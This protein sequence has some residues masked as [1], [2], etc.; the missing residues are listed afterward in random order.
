MSQLSR[1]LL[2]GGSVR[3][4]QPS[5]GQQVTPANG[6]IYA[7]GDVN[8][9]TSASGNTIYAILKNDI[10]INSATVG[11]VTFNANTIGS[12]IGSYLRIAPV[13]NG[14]IIVSYATPRSI[15]LTDS[16]Y[17]MVS[18]STL[19]DG[20]IAI[21][22]SGN[23]PIAANI[24]AGS[25]ISIINGP[26]SITISADSSTNGNAGVLNWS[27]QT[28]TGSGN[29]DYTAMPN[30]GYFANST[31]GTFRSTSYDYCPISPIRYSVAPSIN[32]KVGDAL[33]MCNRNKGNYLFQ[34]QPDQGITLSNLVGA[35]YNMNPYYGVGAL[36]GGRDTSIRS[37]TGAPP[38]R[39]Y[40]RMY[41]AQLWIFIGSINYNVKPAPYQ[42]DNVVYRQYD[43]VFMRVNA[44]GGTS[45][46]PSGTCIQ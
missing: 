40:S 13:G 24:T 10:V 11:S 46:S 34:F 35:G 29:R 28:W 20:Q 37:A 33:W 18:S 45:G 6:K 25:G 22:R 43:N 15:A 42:T 44:I 26:G 1:A 2:Q 41:G 30:N 12:S 5:I 17:Q 32:W 21:G 31:I 36:S 27:T 23:I 4:F 3:A 14:K 9:I 7:L 19:S 39:Y 16:L 38:A 8:T